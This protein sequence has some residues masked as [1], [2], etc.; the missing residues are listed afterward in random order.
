VVV[1]LPGKQDASVGLKG[2]GTHA[3]QPR[4]GHQAASAESAVQPLGRVSRQISAPGPCT[5]G[6]RVTRWIERDCDWVGAREEPS[7]PG[8][9]R[10]RSFAPAKPRDSALTKEAIPSRCAVEHVCVELT[11]ASCDDNDAFPGTYRHVVPATVFAE[12]YPSR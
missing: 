10:R 12:G 9:G 1:L 6:N 2:D 7:P 3:V 5:G 11:F 8:S 4:G